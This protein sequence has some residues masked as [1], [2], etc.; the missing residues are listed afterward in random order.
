MGHF[1]EE[2]IVDLSIVDDLQTFKEGDQEI[3]SL[4]RVAL[5][6]SV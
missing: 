2:K 1:S 4:L 3:L 5:A 6:Y